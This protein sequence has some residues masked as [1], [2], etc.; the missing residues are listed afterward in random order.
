M[1]F[2]IAHLLMVHELCMPVVTWHCV[3][4]PGVY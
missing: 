1:Y 3:I 4:S 2:I